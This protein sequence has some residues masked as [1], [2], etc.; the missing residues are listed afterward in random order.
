LSEHVPKEKNEKRRYQELTKFISFVTAYIPDLND[1]T[2]PE[3][4]NNETHQSWINRLIANQQLVE[5]NVRKFINEHGKRVYSGN[6]LLF[7]S[8]WKAIS[9]II[10]ENP[11]LCS[12]V[13]VFK[14]PRREEV[15]VVEV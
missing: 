6:R 3:V 5:V 4:V 8:A 2:F 1:V 10:A 7:S 13:R 14:R 9:D 12:T 15:Q 11:H